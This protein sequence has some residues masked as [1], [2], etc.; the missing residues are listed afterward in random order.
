MDLKLRSGPSKASQ[1]VYEEK[2]ISREQEKESPTIQANMFS[3]RSKSFSKKVGERERS[4]K[5]SSDAGEEAF[6]WSHQA[7]PG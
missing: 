2:G 3:F 1:I 7:S 6:K 4:Q 5:R